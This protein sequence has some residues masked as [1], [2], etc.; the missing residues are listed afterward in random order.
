MPWTASCMGRCH[1]ESERIAACRL[2]SQT[3]HLVVEPLHGR[4]GGLAHH[5]WALANLGG[6]TLNRSTYAAGSFVPLCAGQP[7]LAVAAGAIAGMFVNHLARAVYS[8]DL[9]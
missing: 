8:A 6:F 2:R 3:N 1:K 4:G 7:V 5:Q 9:G